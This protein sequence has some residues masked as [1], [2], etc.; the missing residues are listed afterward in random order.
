MPYCRECGSYLGAGETFCPSC[1]AAAQPTQ[2]TA[3]QPDAAFEGQGMPQQP[4]QQPDGYQQPVYQ[5]PVNDSGSFGWAVL[6]F[7]IPI[8]GLVLYIVWRTE[9]PRSARM[10]GLGALVS[11]IASVVVTLLGTCASFAL[12]DSV[13]V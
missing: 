10:A 5:Q 6:G 3:Q 1:G 4:F 13:S 7:L 11:V 9:K 8:V 2:A 12:L